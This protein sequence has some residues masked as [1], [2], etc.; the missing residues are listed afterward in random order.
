METHGKWRD[1]MK[2]NRIWAM[3]FAASMMF[4]LPV[5]AQETES[6]ASQETEYFEEIMTENNEEN[7]EIA[8]ETVFETEYVPDTEE[9]PVVESETIDV[10][11]TEIMQDLEEV[12]GT[13]I[14]QAIKDAYE[15]FLKQEENS[16]GVRGFVNRLYEKVL[17]RKADPSGLDT[18]TDLLTSKQMTGAEVA[19]GFIDSTEFKN[20]NL[21]DEAYVT[22]LYNTFFDRGPDAGGKQTWMDAL[23]SGLSRSYVFKGFAESQEFSNLCSKFGIERGSVKLTEARDQNA[24]ITKFVYR[25]Y[26]VFLG[27]QPDASGL[28]MW[29]EMLLTKQM[30]AKEVARGF[31]MSQEFQNKG[32]SNTNYVKTMYIGLFNRNADSGGLQTWVGKLDEGYTREYV[33][34]GFAD[35][36]EFRTL[37]RSFGLSGDWS[38]SLTYI[39]FETEYCSLRLPLSWDG[40]YLCSEYIENDGDVWYSFYN[41]ENYDVYGGM[42]FMLKFEW[43][44]NES[45]EYPS[46]EYLVVTNN[47]ASMVIYPTDV[48]YDY[49]DEYKTDIYCSMS[50]DID[51]I[52][53]TFRL[54]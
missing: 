30:N 39:P 40:H 42:L 52:L 2:V 22:V 41:K 3:A 12:R 36:N 50:D 38:G 48:Q 14:D 11:E 35:S 5:C 34:F 16:T 1:V 7:S 8:V 53:S 46:Y 18:W 47:L 27:R 24:G 51:D 54:K 9:E 33:F 32:L 29:C 19:R 37:A 4:A 26:N 25:C 17:N 31:V 15:E 21:N 45:F 43:A 49:E 44:W 23:A 10:L 6:I 20:R 28:N 13:N